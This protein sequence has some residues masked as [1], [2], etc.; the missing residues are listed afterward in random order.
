[1]FGG[2]RIWL[3]AANSVEALGFSFMIQGFGANSLEALGFRVWKASLGIHGAIRTSW[4][5]ASQHVSKAQTRRKSVCRQFPLRV[6][7]IELAYVT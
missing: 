6:L 1:M 7:R 4:A 5:Q 2:F 3:V